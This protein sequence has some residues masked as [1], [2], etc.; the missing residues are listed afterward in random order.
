MINRKIVFKLCVGYTLI[1]IISMAL[2]GIFFINSF[3]SYTFTN[4]EKNM[5]NRGKDIAKVTSPYL[6]K[7]DDLKEYDNFIG[8]LDSSVNSRI[9]VLN[10]KGDVVAMSNGEIC[11]GES[12]SYC[13]GVKT[14]KDM[15]NRVLEGKEITDEGYSNYY[16]ETMISI[17]V[18]VYDASENVVGAIFLY[19]PLL[20]VT[21][22]IDSV[23]LFLIIAI[24]AASILTGALSLFYSR[25]IVKPLL[26]M[27]GAAKEM[28]EGNYSVRANI[29]QK[30]EIGELGS[31]IDLLASKLGYTMEQLYQESSKLKDL[32]TSISEGILA[33][34]VR[35]KLLNYNEAVK[36]LFEYGR[37]DN[38]QEWIMEYM[39]EAEL[40][41][42]FK[43]VIQCGERR[44]II[45]EFN[46]RKLRFAL[47]PVKNTK[48]EIIGVVALIH[49]VS[50]SERLEQMRREFIANV[51]HELRTPLTLIQGSIEALSEGVVTKE[52]DIKKYY[53][54]ILQETNGLERLV[55]DLM[56]LS[57]LE[58]GEMSLVIDKFDISTLITYV[59]KN[60]QTIAD[61]KMI[62]IETEIAQGIPPVRG[63]YDRIKQVLMIFL[64][65][66]IKYSPEKTKIRIQLE[67]G[68]YVYIKIKDN[69]IGIPKEDI[70]FIWDR[71]YKVDKSRSDTD[72][73]TGLGLS[74]A[75]H[76]IEMHNGIVTVDSEINKGTTFEVGLPFVK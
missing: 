55:S 25:I 16:N 48:N 28:M 12:D 11:V 9:W 65:N 7:S 23:F 24:F 14:D 5:L 29:R 1:I 52:S 36:R 67:V 43:A 18:P 4:K 32:I 30:D 68:D 45:R 26:I 50:E 37:Q 2:I 40:L 64:D 19:S 8:L 31:S 22:T 38:I 34:D 56:D 72:L 70:P 15:V 17:G 60:M 61:K 39:E 75:K 49:D 71:F 41:D 66:A 53:N 21:S 69:G 20:G 74:I 13:N 59:S 35:F 58:S 54:R 33:F 42:E 3:K 63:D 10:K 76:L 51:S 6:I 44:T 46:I 27:N 47:S 57:K 62:G 73:G